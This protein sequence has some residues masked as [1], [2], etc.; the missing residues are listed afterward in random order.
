MHLQK[1]GE[2]VSKEIDFVVLAAFC[3]AFTVIANLVIGWIVRD[4]GH[5]AG[6]REGHAAGFTEGYQQGR[7]CADNW[8]IRED[9]RLD[10]YE[11]G[12]KAA[13]MRRTE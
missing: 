4:R 6:F 10:A 3:V 11:Q 9:A 12:Y 2:S 5:R 8:W 7:L 1:G 13:R